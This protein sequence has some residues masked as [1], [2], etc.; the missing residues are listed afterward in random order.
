MDEADKA[1]MAILMGAGEREQPDGGKQSVQA[2]DSLVSGCFWDEVKL[3]ES[4]WFGTK[5]FV[6]LKLSASAL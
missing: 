5:R 3:E 4:A 1:L 6:D 2:V